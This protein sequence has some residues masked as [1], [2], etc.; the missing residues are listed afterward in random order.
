MAL[1]WASCPTAHAQSESP[2]DR[3]IDLATIE[4]T[5]ELCQFELSDPQSD[6]IA[7]I[8]NAMVDDGSVTSNDIAEIHDQMLATMSR[9]VGEGLCRSEGPGVKFYNKKLA[10]LGVQ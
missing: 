4:I 9:Q 5:S 1:V 7:K 6:A 3:L 8:R 10:T 2:R